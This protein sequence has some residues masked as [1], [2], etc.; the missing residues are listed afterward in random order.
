MR[1]AVY[2]GTGMIGS[3]VA[4]EAGRRGHDSH[5][6]QPDRGARGR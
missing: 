6:H 2:G 5:R 3:R 4:A 1:I